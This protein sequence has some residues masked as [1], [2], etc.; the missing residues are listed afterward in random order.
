MFQ[1]HEE[2]QLSVILL[3]P[4]AM[5]YTC[6]H[7]DVARLVHESDLK[8]ADRCAIMLSPEDVLDVWPRFVSEKFPISRELNTLYMTSGTCEVMLISGPHAARKATSI[9]NQIRRRYQAAPFANLIH[10]P[11]DPVE[12]TS[13][14]AKFFCVDRT[15]EGFERH[16]D[17]SEPVGI[18][19]RFGDEEK[20]EAVMAA[21]QIW[22]KVVKG[23]WTSLW[24]KP[25][26]GEWV[27]H[28]KKGALQSIDFGI[29]ALAELLPE[30]PPHT[31]I[32]SYLEAEHRGEASLLSG[33]GS[34]VRERCWRAVD[35]G[36]LA[37]VEKSK[38]V[39]YGVD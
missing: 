20:E 8:I 17:V 11:T 5:P 34:E 33:T 21:R 1:T 25:V 37:R 32:T 14:V 10:S 6:I 38:L 26:I 24:R 4:D 12:R 16:V 22:A 13:N 39:N 35:L 18:W 9:R 19:G 2:A 31:V 27:L 7:R 30:W 36:I 28:L 29:S 15:T 23:G 3:K